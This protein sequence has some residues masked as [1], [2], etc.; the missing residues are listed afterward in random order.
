MEKYRLDNYGPKVLSTKE[1]LTIII[2]Q[3]AVRKGERQIY[4]DEIAASVLLKAK[5]KDSNEATGLQQ[6]TKKDLTEIEGIGEAKASIIIAALELGKRISNPK[7]NTKT[8][9]DD[10]AVAAAAVMS[11]IGYEPLEH[12]AVLCLDIKHRL[13]STH[14]ISKGTSDETLADPKEVFKKAIEK[15][16]NRLI[17]AHNHPSGDTNPS[18]ADISL[19]KT[20]LDGG[21]I[22]NIPILDHI[23]VSKG[24]F[25]SIRQTNSH[26]WNSD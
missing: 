22:L 25:E 19:T 21:K 13:K 11:D 14:I 7:P 1:L 12:F 4:A 16:A 2:G 8:L 23:I 24:T 6:L 26:L 10:P 17:I 18:D 3:G 15:G 20:L 9:V 5:E